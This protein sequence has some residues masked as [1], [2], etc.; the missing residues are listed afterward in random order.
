MNERTPVPRCQLHSVNLGYET[1]SSVFIL[2]PTLKDYC[3][4]N[5]GITYI[6]YNS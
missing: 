5:L 6:F 4:G 1:K 3:S 2:E